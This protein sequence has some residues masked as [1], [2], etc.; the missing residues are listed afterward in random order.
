M[1]TTTQNPATDHPEVRALEPQNLWRRFAELNAV[2]RPSKQESQVIDF[3]ADF[4]RGLGLETQVD[5]TGNV[6]IRKPATSGLESR[7]P[8]ILQAH[9][10]MVHQKNQG[11][12][13]DFATQGISMQVDG[14]WVTA[15]GTTLGADN[16]I[17]VAAILA[18]LASPDIPHPPL[19]ALLT[20][21]EETGMTGAKGLQ[22]NVL[23]G[24]ILLNLDTEED[25][26][27]TIGCAGGVDVTAAGHYQGQPLPENRVVGRIDIR[28]LAGGHSGMDIHLGRANAN[29]LLAGLLSEATRKFGI[30]LAAIDGGGL[31]NAIPREATATVAVPAD[32]YEKLET[33]LRQESEQ[34]A[35]EY[36]DTDPDLSIQWHSGPADATHGV[37][38]H[39]AETKVAEQKQVGTQAAVQQAAGTEMAEQQQAAGPQAC[40]TQAAGTTKANEQQTVEILPA[41]L[42]QRLL[43]A[44]RACPNGVLRMSPRMAGLVETSNNL[45]RVQVGGGEFQIGCLARSSIDRQRNDVAQALLGLWSLTG[46]EGRTSGD[47][48][49]WQPKPDSGVV[50]LLSD[51]YR[52]RFGSEPKVAACHGGLECGILGSKYPE[53]EMIS[54][55]PNIRGA[56]SPDERVQISSVQK[57]WGYLLEILENIPEPHPT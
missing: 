39:S 12:E 16:G 46:A 37:A 4:G 32:C 51:I 22:P 48:P 8:V 56:H 9:L 44:I 7:T 52:R 29:K 42:Q 3:V 40:G 11:T 14:D 18:I 27:L 2:P 13:F 30:Q 35:A 24:R 15:S 5:D 47:Y 23:T 53:V 17:G 43:A 20:V 19:E 45:A 57:F 10:D 33:W 21:D 36:V 41:E 54:F 38:E 25:D 1:S 28:G 6:I 34:I 50:K 55:G 31:R 26:E 49:G